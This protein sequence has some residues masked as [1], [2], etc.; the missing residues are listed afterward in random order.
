IGPGD[1]NPDLPGLR[2]SANQ[3]YIHVESKPKER[4]LVQFR[5]LAKFCAQRV[6]SGLRH[7]GGGMLGSDWVLRTPGG[8]I[9]NSYCVSD[10]S[11]RGSVE[12]NLEEWVGIIRE[13]AQKNG[14]ASAMVVGEEFVVHDGP[15]YPLSRCQSRR[16]PDEE[17]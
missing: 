8:V 5:R 15:S 1:P 10:Y 7:P 6:K 13:F 16:V 4:Y 14:L 17:G 12:E 11:G 9:F 3:R 2:R